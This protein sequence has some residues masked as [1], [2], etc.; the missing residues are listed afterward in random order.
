MSFKS[1]YMIVPKTLNRSLYLSLALS[2]SLPPS[3]S[4]SL[5][6]SL[7]LSPSLSALRT[8]NPPKRGLRHIALVDAFRGILGMFEGLEASGS[9][10]FGVWGLGVEGSRVSGLGFGVWGLGFRV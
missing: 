10:G 1:L 4:L 5:C 6:L 9:F 8:K 7:S 3:P 2:P